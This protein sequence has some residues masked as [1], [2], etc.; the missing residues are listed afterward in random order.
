M[1]KPPEAKLESLN[2]AELLSLVATQQNEDAL[3]GLC[4]RVFNDKLSGKAIYDY[5]QFQAI[6]LQ[7]SQTLAPSYRAKINFLIG[8]EAACN[9]DAAT[10]YQLFAN[11]DEL[12]FP[13]ATCWRARLLAEGIG[14]A[15]NKAEAIN[16]FRTITKTVPEASF[17]LA[18]LY[19]ADPVLKEEVETIRQFYANAKAVTK[20]SV[21][22]DLLKIYQKNNSAPE[23]F[24]FAQAGAKAGIPFAIYQLGLCYLNG[25]EVGTDPKQAVVWLEKAAALKSSDAMN[26]VGELYEQGTVVEKD[27]AKAAAYFAQAAEA[28]NSQGKY[29]YQGLYNYARFLKDGLGGVKRDITQARLLSELAAEAGLVQAQCLHADILAETVV[30]FSVYDHD[31]DRWYMKAADQGSIYAMYRLGIRYYSTALRQ[32]ETNKVYGLN[33]EFNNLKKAVTWFHKAAALGCIR[34][35]NQIC[36]INVN[37]RYDLEIVAPATIYQYA[38]DVLRNNE[39]KKLVANMLKN[40]ESL[41]KKLADNRFIAQLKRDEL[42]YHRERIN[43]TPSWPVLINFLATNPEPVFQSHFTPS[44]LIRS[45][46]ALSDTELP[47]LTKHGATHL[48]RL[49]ITQL[50]TDLKPNNIVDQRSNIEKTL[51]VLKKLTTMLSKP[52]IVPAE[53]EVI[54]QCAKLHAQFHT[55][56]GEV[57]IALPH[58][59]KLDGQ[60]SYH[61]LA[62][63]L[64]RCDDFI[65][66]CLDN[67]R[68]RYLVIAHL[69][70]LT[71]SVQEDTQQFLIRIVY[72]LKNNKKDCMSSEAILELQQLPLQKYEALRIN[73][74]HPAE[75]FAFKLPDRF[76]QDA[77]NILRNEANSKTLNDNKVLTFTIEELITTVG[78]PQGEIDLSRLQLIN[79][80]LA[81]ISTNEYLEKLPFHEFHREYQQCWELVN[82]L[83]HVEHPS[84]VM[85]LLSSLGPPVARMSEAYTLDADTKKP[86]DMAL[87]KD[88]LTELQSIMDVCHVFIDALTTENQKYFND[89]KTQL[90]EFLA[91]YS[92]LTEVKNKFSTLFASAPAPQQTLLQ[93][94]RDLLASMQELAKLN[95]VVNAQAKVQAPAPPTLKG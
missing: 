23:I 24:H 4:Q 31:P 36:Q 26:K 42:T 61:H 38:T 9:G 39:D 12:G 45:G 55:T 58:I 14:I 47:Q 86:K 19:E 57:S 35:K 79:Q 7:L 84:V 34:S 44:Q 49:L 5:G 70:L 3:T 18:R 93:R 8:A 73:I 71:G 80:F 60:S 83:P 52:P 90:L 94:N 17:Y 78:L 27:L 63:L 28:K 22:R 15:S 68:K 64:F 10:S 1:M 43:S 33:G 54:T 29:N 20:H 67:W 48:A 91:P 74:N 53:K 25:I 66:T 75:K 16:K 37:Y 69:L 51:A 50:E 2:N 81:E 11:A 88:L 85:R 87:A 6:K 72:S 65:V 30:V 46:F 40:W 32:A 92:V 77:L 56:L 59:L 62:T 82:K 89:T 76:S 13:L 95:I 21:I 41:R